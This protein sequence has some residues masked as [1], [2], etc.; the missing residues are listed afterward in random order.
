M[1]TIDYY[2]TDPPVD[3]GWSDLGTWAEVNLYFRL[4]NYYTIGTDWNVVH[5]ALETLKKSTPTV[6]PIGTYVHEDGDYVDPPGA[7]AFHEWTRMTVDVVVDDS[8]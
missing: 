8:E 7:A 1:R 4:E 6:S 3:S 2:Q 5:I